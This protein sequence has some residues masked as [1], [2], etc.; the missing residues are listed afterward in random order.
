[1]QYA[2]KEYLDILVELVKATKTHPEL[3][4]TIGL[5]NFDAQHT[6]EA[7][8]HLLETM[9]EVGLVTN[10]VQF[11][12]IDSRPLQEMSAVCAKYGL[13]L[14]TY[15]SFVSTFHHVLQSFRPRAH[16][17]AVVGVHGEL[18]RRSIQCGG[19]ISPRWLGQPIPEIYSEASQLTP[20]QRKV[21]PISTGSWFP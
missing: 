6:E 12:L 10:Q 15:G 18:T 11:S 9:G 4:S 17:L 5:C 14:L 19:F 7:C 13:K 20:S 2:A 1:M 3:V 21:S 8:R 16:I